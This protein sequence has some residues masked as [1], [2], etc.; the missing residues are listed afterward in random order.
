M[1]LNS[2]ESEQSK[3]DSSP[4]VSSLDWTALD[5]DLA[6]MQTYIVLLRAVNVGGTGK[7]PMSEFKTM[8]ESVGYLRVQTYIASGN[9]LF[10]TEC[11]AA[12]IKANLETRLQS[13]FGKSNDVIVRTAAEM[14][15]VLKSNPFS[16]ADASHTVAIFLN[17]TPS[18]IVNLRGQKDEELQLGVREIFVHYPDGIGASKLVIPIAKTGTARNMRTIAKLVDLARAR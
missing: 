5:S 10:D 12:T 3:L 9:V 4:S 6:F 11:D 8:C 16:N 17:N 7:L 18:D 2:V 1:I 15:E 13:F 14:A